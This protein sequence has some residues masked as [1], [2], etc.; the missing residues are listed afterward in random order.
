M[1][2]FILLSCVLALFCAAP[3]FSRQEQA[4]APPAASQALTESLELAFKLISAGQFQQAR[5]ELEK[6]TALARGPC[7]VCLVGMAHVYAS[8]KK[9]DQVINAAQQALPL[10]KAPGPQARALNQLGIAYVALNDLAKAEEALRRATDLG[11]AWGTIARYNLAEVLYRLQSWAAAA[12][13]ARLYLKEAAPGS[14][15]L[16]ETRALL[17]RARAHLPD[18][19]ARPVVGE[20]PEPKRVE[21]G[22]QRPEIIAQVKPAYTREARTAGTTGAVIVEAIIDEEGC[23][24]NVKPL[25]ELPNG[26]TESAVEAVR[27]WVFSPATLAGKPVKVYYVLTINFQVQ[28]DS[29]LPPPGF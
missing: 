18:E 8:E 28:H 15:A 19:P 6:A 11:G 4:T 27:R 5:T 16:K 29:P 22:V 1:R 23:V 17:C 10:L 21:G 12:E 26:L 7:G 9:W 20:N 13:A 3:G 25:Q 24:R 2:C 14:V